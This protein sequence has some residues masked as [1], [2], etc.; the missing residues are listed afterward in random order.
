M[1]AFFNHFN[2]RK[3]RQ[4]ILADFYEVEGV[5]FMDNKIYTISEIREKVTPIAKQYGVEKVFLFGSYARGDATQDSDIDL[6]VDKGKV[7]G[8]GFGSLC[9]AF[10]DAFGKSVDVV[11]TPSLD[12]DFLNQIASDEVL[13]YG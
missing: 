11:T 8:F 6:R 1:E 12:A 2:H 13:I 10:L 3:Y 7:T 5:I 4:G 9:N